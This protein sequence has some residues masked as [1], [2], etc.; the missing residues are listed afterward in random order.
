MTA[1]ATTSAA[2]R[3]E[4]ERQVDRL[5]ELAYPALLGVGAAEFRRR[6]APLSN[7]LDRL[8]ATTAVLREDWV[9]FVLVVPGVPAAVAAERMS[10]HGRGATLMIPAAEVDSYRPIRDVR[11]PAAFA[12]LLADVDTGTEFCNV[13]PRDALPTMLGRGRSPLTIAEG[14]ALVTQRPDMLR[15]NKCF[16]L[17]ASRRDDQRVPAIW[18]SARAPKL[19][20]CFNGAPHTWLGAA[21]AGARLRSTTARPPTR[22]DPVGRSTP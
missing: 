13:R 14:V 6:L 1:A 20:W 5:I 21:S 12:Y 19:G 18:I 16:S 8:A 3:D 11:L 15:P 17:L 10:L 9:P 2:A 22:R 7:A 4:L